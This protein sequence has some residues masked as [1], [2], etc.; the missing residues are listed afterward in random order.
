MQGRAVAK[1]MSGERT[2]FRLTTSY[3]MKV[4]GMDVMFIGDTRREL[5][6]EILVRGTVESGYIIQMFLSGEKIVGAT[7]IGANTDRMTLTKIIDQ[8]IT[9]EN[10]KEELKNPDFDLKQLLS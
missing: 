6:S 2:L 9:I 1:T 5:A 3:A 4:L 8:Q 7:L 10:R